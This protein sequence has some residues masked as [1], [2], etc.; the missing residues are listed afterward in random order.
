MI[1][2]SKIKTAATAVIKTGLQK[3]LIV[4]GI[5]MGTSVFLYEAYVRIGVSIAALFY[6][7]GP[8]IVMALSPLFS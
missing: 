2:V 5:A 8:V 4:S 3:C 1:I 7:C 6:Y